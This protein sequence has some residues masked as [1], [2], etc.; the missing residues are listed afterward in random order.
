[1]VFVVNVSTFDV[2]YDRIKPLTIGVN[3]KRI[4]LVFGIKV[5]CSLGIVFTVHEL[6][7]RPKTRHVFNMKKLIWLLKVITDKCRVLVCCEL[8]SAYGNFRIIVIS[9]LIDE[10]VKLQ[11]RQNALILR[12]SLLCFGKLFC[13]FFDPVAVYVPALRSF[14]F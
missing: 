13:L 7:Q 10:K 8:L 3:K 5:T 9:H 4:P 1:M 12:T 6:I 2:V 14:V 11:F